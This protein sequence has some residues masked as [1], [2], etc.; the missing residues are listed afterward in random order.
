MHLKEQGQIVPLSSNTTGNGGSQ[1]GSSDKEKNEG[2]REM[3]N[4]DDVGD[5]LDFVL[6]MAEDVGLVE[7]EL[8]QE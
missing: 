6:G 7:V 4:G 2:K 8:A 1:T 3:M 5:G